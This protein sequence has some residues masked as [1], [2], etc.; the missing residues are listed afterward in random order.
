MRASILPYFQE[1]LPCVFMRAEVYSRRYWQLVA[2]LYP[3][4]RE[5]RERLELAGA[6]LPIVREA[7]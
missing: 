2:R 7:R 6:A 5:A 4:W 3:G 1:T